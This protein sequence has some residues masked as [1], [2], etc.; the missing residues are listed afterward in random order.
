MRALLLTLILLLP[1]LPGHAQT[2]RGAGARPCAEWSQARRG[3]GRDFDAEQWTLGYISAITATNAP[4]ARSLLHTTDEKGIF[5][6]IG[7]YCAMHPDDMLW[8]AVKSALAAANG[9]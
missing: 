8:H 4:G 1:A 2:I 5:A 3:G 9:A 7:G 6:A